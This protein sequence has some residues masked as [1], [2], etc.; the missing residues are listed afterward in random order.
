MNINKPQ[1][2]FIVGAPRSS[3]N[4]INS[5]LD[6]HPDVLSWPTECHYF[7][8]FK[9]VAGT[10]IKASVQ[11]LNKA[12]LEH[13]TDRLEERLKFH[14]VDK[15]YK[16]I[17]I[18]SELGEFDLN[19]F[20]NLLKSKR[21][22]P[23][24][25]KTEHLRFI[26][27]TFHQSHAKYANKPVMY[28]AMMCTARGYDWDDENLIT[29]NQLIF[30]FRPHLDSYASLRDVYFNDV[31][32]NEFFNWRNRKGFIYWLNQYVE[33][34]QHLKLHNN[35]QN[36]H[37]LSVAKL[38]LDPQNTIRNICSFLGI[39]FTPEVTNM[40]MLGTPYG[41]NAREQ[42]LSTSQVAARPS[43]L[44]HPLMDFETKMFNNLGL[45][46]F[47]NQFHNLKK[48]NFITLL[49]SAFR[50]SFFQINLSV[51]S[52]QKRDPAKL[53]LHWR[54]NLFIKFIRIILCIRKCELLP[55][56]Q[57][58]NLSDTD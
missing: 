53:L 35:R 21:N 42:S 9:S 31:T 17:N 18:S 29:E 37:V 49:V 41:G 33:M 46:D 32:L 1:F 4:T 34:S 58:K 15:K 57:Q 45:F 10:N 5:L 48:Y 14:T 28:Y 36:L 51:F 50:T 19:T 44:S 40:T 13:F 6:N 7:T 2:I 55:L 25:T 30:P 22:P 11:N 8:I 39:S 47:D 56:T 26:F 38:R 24:M 20:T 23:T 3:N 54:I 16:E 52:N 27:E 43:K 12:F